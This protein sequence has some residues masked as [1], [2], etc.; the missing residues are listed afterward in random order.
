[1]PLSLTDGVSMAELAQSVLR[2]AP[3]R[4]SLAALSMG[5]H[6]AMEIMRQAPD[7]V[8]RLALIDTRADVDSPER[9]KTRV[10]DDVMVKNEGFSALVDLLPGRWMLPAHAA[11]PHLRQLVIDMAMETGLEG[12]HRQLQ[13]LLGRIDSRASLATISCP[14]LVMCGR[15]DLAN[16]VWMHEEMAK[17]VPAAQLQIIE[18]CGH[19]SPVE[20]PV[21]VSSALRSW[22][23]V[24]PNLT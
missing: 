23:H 6:V 9:L 15:Q 18:D 24:A 2:R 5:G 3:E 11:I 8:E 4:F 14:T 19:L 20:Q 1:M 7:R 22:L 17:L 12:R 21:A 10:D 13:A 16:P